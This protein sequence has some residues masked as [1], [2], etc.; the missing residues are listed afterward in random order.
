MAPS[1]GDCAEL[2]YALNLY[3]L[4]SVVSKSFFKPKIPVPSL[5]LASLVPSIFHFAAEGSHCSPKTT[6]HAEYAIE[7]LLLSFQNNSVQ[8]KSF[9]N[10][11]MYYNINFRQEVFFSFYNHMCLFSYDNPSIKFYHY[12]YR[13]LNLYTHSMTLCGLLV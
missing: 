5:K 1:A 7:E 12:L 6:D 11:M 3:G 13:A 8:L 2:R 10:T 9:H 4:L